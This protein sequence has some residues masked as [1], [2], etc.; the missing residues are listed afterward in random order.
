MNRHISFTFD[1]EG[2]LHDIPSPSLSPEQPSTV[3]PGHCYTLGTELA[4][5]GDT[6]FFRGTTVAFRSEDSLMLH[7][8]TVAA[9]AGIEP[10][11]MHLNPVNVPAPD[12]NNIFHINTQGITD[13]VWVSRLHIPGPCTVTLGFALVTR[14]CSVKG[15]FSTTLQ[16]TFND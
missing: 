14:S 9:G 2:I 8:L 11:Q 3:K 15:Y 7:A 4:R 13:H 6:L 16:L 1:A 12:V 10:A 5:T